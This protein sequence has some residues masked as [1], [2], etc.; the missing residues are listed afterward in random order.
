MAPVGD[1]EDPAVFLT[2]QGPMLHEACHRVCGLYD[3]RIEVF[4]LCFRVD[5]L[6]APWTIYEDPTLRDR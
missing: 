5:A 3:A 1:V 4:D 6:F 2:A